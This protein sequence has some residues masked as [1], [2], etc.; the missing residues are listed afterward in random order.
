MKGDGRVRNRD[1]GRGGGI[2]KGKISASS[3]MLVTYDIERDG[4]QICVESRF[5]IDQ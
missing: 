5:G 3:K 4:T 1:A 2:E